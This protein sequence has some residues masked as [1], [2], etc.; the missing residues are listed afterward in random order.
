MRSLDARVLLLPLGMG[1]LVP[2]LAL[3]VCEGDC[4]EQIYCT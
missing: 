3:A 2:V 1:L 4:P